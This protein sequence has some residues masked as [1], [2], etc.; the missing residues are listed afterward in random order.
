MLLIRL[1]LDHFRQHRSTEIDFQAGMTAIVGANGTGKTTILEATTYALYGAQ[2]DTKETI[3]FYWGETGKKKFGAELTFELD[4]IRYTVGRSNTDAELQE[5]TKEGIKQLAAGPNDVKRYC[6]RLLGLTYEQFINSF[7]AEQKNLAFLNFRTSSVRQEEVARMLGFDR[8]KRAEEIAKERRSSLK[9]KAETLEKTLGNLG[10]LERDKKQATDKLK[11]IDAQAAAMEKERKALDLQIPPA[12]ELRT[13]AEKWQTLSSEMKEIGGEAKG[14]K[15]AVTMAEGAFKEAQKNLAE[16]RE[17]EPKEQE[18]ARLQIQNKDWERKREDDVKREM[19]HGEIKR[20]RDE[21]A[22]HEQDLKLLKLTD[23]AVLEKAFVGADEAL[24]RLTARIQDLDKKWKA[25]LSKAQEALIDATARLDE[26][27][28]NLARCEEMVA[29]GQCPECGQPLAE[30]YAPRIERARTDLVIRQKQ[31]AAAVK[32][33]EQALQK[34]AELA[35]AEAELAPAKSKLEETRKARELAAIAQ[36]QAKTLMGEKAKKSEA[37]AKLEAKLANMPPIYDLKK[38]ESVK[39][40]L[41]SLEPQHLRFLGLQGCEKAIKEREQDHKTATA[42]YEKAKAQY[43][44]LETER[45]ALSFDSQDDVTQAIAAHQALDQKLRDTLSSLKNASSLK[46]L[47]DAA[48]KQAQARLDEHH[49][50]AKELD[51]ARK[52]GASYDT[53][54]KEMR[55]LR[56]RLNRSIGPDLE[57]RASENLNLLTNGRYTTLSLDNNFEP[58]VIDDGIAKSVISGGEEDV[59]ALALRLALSELIQERNGRPMSLLV[60]DEVFGSLDVERR[61]SV[62]DRLASLK[63]RFRQIFVISHIEEIN[64]VADQALYITRDPESRAAVLSDAPPDAA[65]LLL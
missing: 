52:S 54:A 56:E 46:E 4:G 39:K 20:L 26:A 22:G 10:D 32:V 12:K 5:H 17:L 16:F 13:K 11:E 44:K 40:S 47:A 48:A 24:T 50:R 59:V 6:E 60:L 23:V 7:C 34:P 43:K 18:Y 35:K 49:A 29:K 42:N 62:L 3:R 33:A 41:E 14:L 57:A 51:E 65:P 38:H 30:G 25:E 21:I 8:L 27:Q 1:K 61:Q 37:A 64:Q 19:A 55:N 53:V 9:T 2:R 63:G 31:K 28:K 58:T 15:D 36:A 45:C